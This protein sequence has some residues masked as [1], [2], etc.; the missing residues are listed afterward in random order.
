MAAANKNLAEV[1]STDRDVAEIGGK[2]RPIDQFSSI[3]SSQVKSRQDTSSVTHAWRQ[4]TRRPDRTSL[5]STESGKLRRRA[6]DAPRDRRRCSGPVRSVGPPVVHVRATET[7][8]EWVELVQQYPREGDAQERNSKGTTVAYQSLERSASNRLS[9][10]ARDSAR[11]RQ[12]NL[13]VSNRLN[14]SARDS[15]SADLGTSAQL[16]CVRSAQRLRP[17][18]RQCLLLSLSDAHE[19]LADG[20]LACMHLRKVLVEA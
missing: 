3:K 17:R 11:A 1:A 9:A 12:P 15:A 7:R 14:A 10:S 5:R 6:V 16:G 8:E 19:A 2:T 18:Q 13:A 20:L 4:R